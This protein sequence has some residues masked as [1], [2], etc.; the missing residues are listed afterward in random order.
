[1]RRFHRLMP[2]AGNRRQADLSYAD[3]MGEGA[4]PERRRVAPVVRPP[5]PYPAVVS[6]RPAADRDAESFAEETPSAAIVPPSA[7]APPCGC[8]GSATRPARPPQRPEG[9]TAPAPR[10]MPP[11]A[12]SP[13]PAPASDAPVASPGHVYAPPNARPH[14]PS[15]DASIF[16]TPPDP[17]AVTTAT[18]WPRAATDGDAASTGALR[19]LGVAADLIT[20]F[21]A[22]GMAALRP[23]ASAFGEAA[24]TELLRR[25]R[26]GAARLA[27]PPHSYDRE[28]DLTRAF[29]RPVARPA[30]LAIRLLLAIPGHFRELA[31][32]AP[33]DDEAYA[34]ENLGWLLMHALAADVRRA[35]GLDFWLPAP[36]AFVTRFDAAV[37]GLSP[38]VTQLIAARSLTD[39][40]LDAAAYRGKLT[41]WQSGA[42]GR[43]WRLETGRDTSAGRAA[44]VPFYPDPFTIPGPI[45]IT[46]ERA[47]VRAAWA[48]RLADFDAGRTASPLTTC[49][50]A[51]LRQ[52]G[53]M[54]RVAL[55]GLQ[56]RTQF[57]S[58]SSASTL[59]SLDGLAA[60]R[61]AFEAAFQAVVD[62][63]WNDLLFETQG[64]G[65]FRGK[66]VPG[67]PALAR[68]MS[69]HSLGIAIDLNVFEN[70]QNTPSSMDPRIVALF[71]AFRFRWGKGFPTPDP[72]HF[73]YAG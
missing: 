48:H 60:V 39:G 27:Q 5:Q 22:A 44:G 23:I 32:R 30:V 1:M 71:E 62:L 8:G 63:G 49:D 15:S 46:A 58:P 31:R 55:R 51:Y 68:Q 19:A 59:S 20:A 16:R 28:A 50:N 56:L 43:M 64:M 4:A 24:L 57:P 52:A 9:D 17:V 6:V 14:T 73:E 40:S 69:E 10:P 35:T 66:K 36:P 70:G 53:L 41:A 47:Q 72:M 21:G 67:R 2:P 42:P 11:P 65:C 45:N 29:G 25:L 7:P 34:I 18:E 12:A 38:Q 54:S 37:S 13:L 3:L 61:P 33:S 26:Y